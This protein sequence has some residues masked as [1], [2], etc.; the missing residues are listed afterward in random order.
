MNSIRILRTGAS[1]QQITS[2]TN[3]RIRASSFGRRVCWHYIAARCARSVPQLSEK[4]PDAFALVET[5]GAKWSKCMHSAVC[6]YI[7]IKMA[8]KQ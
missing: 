2:S 4:S 6:L 3:E 8:R 1:S 5:N 7:E